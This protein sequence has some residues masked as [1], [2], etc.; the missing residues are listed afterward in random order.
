[1]KQKFLKWFLYTRLWHFVVKRMVKGS[2]YEDAVPK[3]YKDWGKDNWP[4][5]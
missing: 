2:Q 3:D 5:A 4:N 1:M